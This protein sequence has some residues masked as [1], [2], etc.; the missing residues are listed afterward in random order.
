M[1]ADGLRLP[2]EKMGTNRF[3]IDVEIVGFEWS[4]ELADC[5]AE[6]MESKA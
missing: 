6:T 2:A 4:E 1:N 5:K 3:T